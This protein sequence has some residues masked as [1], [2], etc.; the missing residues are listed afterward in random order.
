MVLNT[1]FSVVISVYKNDDPIFFSQALES[2]I[3]QSIN[4]TEIVLVVDGPINEKINIVINEAKEIY[5]ELKVIRL[6]EN[7]G[8]AYARQTG[9]EA[10]S[11]NLVALMDSD[12]ISAF[13]RFEKQLRV[14]SE[15]P[16]IDV[17]G[18]QISEFIDSTYN[19]IGK[20]IVPL[21]DK[22]IKKYMKTRCPMNQVSVMFK[23]E[24]VIKAGGYIDWHYEEDYYLWIRMHEKGF[25]FMNIN[26]NLVYVRVGD[27][28]YKRRGGLKYFKSETLLQKYM[29]QKKIISS[30]IFIYNIIVRFIVQVGLPNKIRGWIFQY[31]FRKK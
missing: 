24:S 31:F 3:N 8:H 12:D 25:I 22:E 26:E 10:T 7:K 23:K 14:F 28:M 11:Y 27:E 5:K 1:S 9:I 2:I 16:N 30:P 13:Y 29:L 21:E 18:G 15:E 17:L 19:I 6:H 4:P 20:R